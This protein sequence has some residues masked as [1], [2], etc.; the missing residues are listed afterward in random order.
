RTASLEKINMEITFWQETSGKPVTI[1]QVRGDLTANEPLEGE[2]RKAF[3]GGARDM[4]LDLSHT[5]YISSAGLRA[6]H[7]IYMLLRSADPVDESSAVR[8]IARGTYKSPHLKL[9][10][11]S[12]N[13]LKAL[14]T[15]GYDIFLELHNSLPEAV[16]SFG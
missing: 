4:V 15:A 3:A 6:I 9:V 14:T 1:L 11:P 5:P 8:D 12:K 10:K 2:A 13:G 16:A 7:T